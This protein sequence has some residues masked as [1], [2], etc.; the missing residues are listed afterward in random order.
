[1]WQYGFVIPNN[2][3]DYVGVVAAFG[4]HSP[5]YQTKKDMLAEMGLEVRKHPRCVYCDDPKK[6]FTTKI[7]SIY[8]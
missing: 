3:Y 1:V 2:P 5:D 4:S 7:A 8:C 6:E